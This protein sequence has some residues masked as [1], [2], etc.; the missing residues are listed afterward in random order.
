M[1]KQLAALLGTTLAI[2]IAAVVPPAQAGEGAKLRPQPASIQAPLR[3]SGCT[4]PDLKGL[5]CATLTVPLDYA[6]PTGAKA[7]LAITRL[8]HSSS[9][10]DYQ[11]VMI[12]NPGG[13]GGSGTWLPYL[14]G[15]VPGSSASTYDWIGFDPR[16]VGGSTPTL[17]CRPHYFKV[18][19]PPYVPWTSRLMG[20]WRKRSADYATSC[21]RAPGRAI[22]EH[23]KTTDTVQDLETLRVAL[24]QD[25]INYYGFSYGT[26]IG[27]V[28]ATLH[29]DR[30]GRFVF[31]GVVDPSRIWYPA[32]LDQDIAF[33]V[34]MTSFWKWMAKNHSTYGVSSNWRTIRHGYYH[35][36]GR[37]KRHPWRHRLGA[38]ELNGAMVGAG[39]YVYGWEATAVAFSKLRHKHNGGPML[40]LYK[41]GDFAD[42]NG[43][44]IYN[45]TQCSDAQ[46]P[47][48]WRSW[49][50]D[51]WNIHVQRPF[52]AWNN[53]WYNAPCFTWPATPSTPVNV[54]GSAVHAPILLV[55]ETRDAATPY[56]G[57][58]EVRRRFPKSSLIAGIGGTTHA[59]SLSGVSCT[60]DAIAAYLTDG[61][62]P[63]RT[64][65]DGY[66][67]GCPPVPAAD[68]TARQRSSRQGLPMHLRQKLM[69]ANQH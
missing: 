41:Q 14:A 3:W 35:E 32:S 25:R 4:S 16:G 5:E 46:W 13:P 23:V 59:G 8:L 52:L 38:D 58:L 24:G 50:D 15:Y 61:T 31:D 42:E 64:S 2:S 27:Q 68:P 6:N 69:R 45:A 56:S 26:Y 37:L 36:I 18:N 47:Q 66:D 67:L 62:V 28:Y 57:A 12:G 39:Y 60:D 30:V 21:S 48:S 34:A 22:L 10:A 51:T 9:A 7:H 44:A 33:G 65:G 63:T 43:Y 40:A 54:T 29:P 19:R 11:G 20:I 55:N 49:I 17:R 1:K 53:T